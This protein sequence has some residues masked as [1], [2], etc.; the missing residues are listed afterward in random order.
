MEAKLTEET[1]A[2][3]RVSE[4]GLESVDDS[5]LPTL[6]CLG[7]RVQ[8]L[9]LLAQ[10]EKSF[11]IHLHHFQSSKL[12]V[13]LCP[14]CHFLLRYWPYIHTHYDIWYHMVSLRV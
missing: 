8:Q 5:S 12:V 1:R 4:L 7:Q 13:R 6:I 14:F 3:T 10:T 9:L 11:D 2:R